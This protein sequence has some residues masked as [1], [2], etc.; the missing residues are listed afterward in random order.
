MKEPCAGYRLTLRY[1][2][3]APD[4]VATVNELLGTEM[5]VECDDF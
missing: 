2:G 1:E 5:E 4:L 3:T